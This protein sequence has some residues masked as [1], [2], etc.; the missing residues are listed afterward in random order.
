MLYSDAVGYQ[1]E[2]N[3]FLLR[4]PLDMHTHSVRELA[5]FQDPLE[6]SME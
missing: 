5:V 2:G 4:P 3:G 6:G 1:Y